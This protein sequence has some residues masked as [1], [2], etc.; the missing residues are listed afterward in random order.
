[1]V[2]KLP[3]FILHI[4]CALALFVGVNFVTA[5]E[6][7]VES[8]ILL[9][10]MQEFEQRAA[11]S[12]TMA[13][14]I[15]A[16]E[17][18]TLA[19]LGPDEIAAAKSGFVTVAIRPNQKMK[20]WID[21]D[22]ESLHE[23]AHDVQNKMAS[24]GVPIVA[25]GPIAF[26]LTLTINGET[27]SDKKSAAKETTQPGLNGPPV[28]AAWR[29]ALE[30]TKERQLK[31]PDDILPLVWPVDEMAD[32]DVKPEMPGQTFVPDGYVLQSLDPLG[33]SL[34]RPKDWHYSEG[35]REQQFMWTV[36]KE[37]PEGG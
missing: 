33:G 20:L 8:V 11:D 37:P 3:T 26:M 22:G 9:N 36:S 7:K 2:P 32:G 15:K 30:K 28:P 27:E 6:V 13:G 14:Y 19:R 12:K 1:M 34:A 24:K 25:G 10:R 16:I 17:K 4:A 21:I 29:D 18:T 5:E 31:I 23:A 35:H